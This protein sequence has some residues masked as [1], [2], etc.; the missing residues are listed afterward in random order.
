MIWINTFAILLFWPM[1]SS[2]SEA[3]YGACLH[4]PQVV[5]PPSLS[6]LCWS[7]LLQQKPRMDKPTPVGFRQ[8]LCH[9]TLWQRCIQFLAILTLDATKSHTGLLKA[10]RRQNK[11]K[12]QEEKEKCWTI[13][14]LLRWGDSLDLINLQP[15]TCALKY[16]NTIVSEIFKLKSGLCL[17]GNTSRCVTVL[18]VSSFL[19]LLLQCFFQL[20]TATLQ[21]EYNCTMPQSLSSPV[22]AHLSARLSVLLSDCS[23]VCLQVHR[24]RKL[25]VSSAC[26]G[27]N[28]IKWDR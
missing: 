10:H 1:S 5:G 2:Q 8:G 7:T 4:L 6:P 3:K 17:A 9:F 15:S 13:S 27:K 19:F 23:C 22:C 28:V 25:S 16:F 18:C 11:R 14:A 20:T 26:W 21:S 12:G 24:G